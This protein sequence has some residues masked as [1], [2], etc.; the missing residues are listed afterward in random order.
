MRVAQR[1]VVE[2]RLVERHAVSPGAVGREVLAAA[3]VVVHV[4]EPVATGTRAVERPLVGLAHAAVELLVLE[5]RD[6]AD[7]GAVVE[8]HVQVALHHMAERAPRDDLLCVNSS[9]A[10]MSGSMY[11][12]CCIAVFGIV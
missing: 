8:H 9:C 12:V 5:Q 7:A 2:S 6:A 4:A 1:E 3:E 10:S 11:D